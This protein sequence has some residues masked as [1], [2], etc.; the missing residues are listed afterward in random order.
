MSKDAPVLGLEYRSFTFALNILCFFPIFLYVGN[1]DS[2]RS[3][4]PHDRHPPDHW[5]K[6]RHHAASHSNYTMTNSNDLECPYATRICGEMEP[7][8]YSVSETHFSAYH[9][10][11]GGL[12]G[13]ESDHAEWPK[14]IQRKKS[15][16]N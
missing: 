5:Q 13:S 15:I 8:P 3:C 11:G 9:L 10:E 16:E 4:F 2:F 6:E 1:R 7:S 12:E 14:R